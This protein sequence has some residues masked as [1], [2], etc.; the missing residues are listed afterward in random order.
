MQGAGGVL[1][2]QRLGGCGGEGC[3][4][5]GPGELD[6]VERG[7]QG[8]VVRVVEEPDVDVGEDLLPAL[9]GE[10]D[11]NGCGLVI[12]GPSWLRRRGWRLLDGAGSWRAG[13]VRRYGCQGGVGGPGGGGCWRQPLVGGDERGGFIG[14]DRGEPPF[15]PVG[16]ALSGLLGCVWDR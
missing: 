12:D 6:P 14:C 5:V 9:A 8:G 1:V 10:G 7:G 4:H 13:Q 15:E 2:G 11:G 3:G 16:D